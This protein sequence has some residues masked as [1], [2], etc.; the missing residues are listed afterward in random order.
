MYLKRIIESGKHG[1]LFTR[2]SEDGCVFVHPHGGQGELTVMRYVLIIL[3]AGLLIFLAA[4]FVIDRNYPYLLGRRDRLHYK[5]VFLSSNMLLA[6]NCLYRFAIEKGEL[7]RSQNG[8]LPDSLVPYVERELRQRSI[9]DGLGDGLLPNDP[10]NESGAMW[11]FTNHWKSMRDPPITLWGGPIRYRV[12]SGG[13]YVLYSL[14]PD[15]K[16]DAPVDS[17]FAEGVSDEERRQM[18]SQTWYDPSNGSD[19]I[20]DLVYLG[21][22]DL[23]K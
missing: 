11:R 4:L 1:G 21:E 9:G 6:R 7:P 16:M 10:F 2:G 19:S 3:I 14:G 15:G 13:R 17:I 5:E 20:G 18:L 12:V 8:V 23:K 22:V